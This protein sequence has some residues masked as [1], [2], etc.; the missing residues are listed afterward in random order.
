MSCLTRL[1]EDVWVGY[2]HSSGEVV[3]SVFRFKLPRNKLGL[4]SLKLMS[5][6]NIK[7]MHQT[8]FIFSDRRGAE[9]KYGI[10]SVDLRKE[11]DIRIS[12]GTLFWLVHA[13]W[14]AAEREHSDYLKSPSH[15]SAL[16]HP[17]MWR[18]NLSTQKCSN[19]NIIF[20]VMTRAWPCPCC[21]H[22]TADAP[23]GIDSTKDWQH[24]GGERDWP[25]SKTIHHV[26]HKAL[27]HVKIHT[28]K[29]LGSK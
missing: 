13:Q 16:G 9:S 7:L 21:N 18:C 15:Q 25:G 11:T 20:Y 27:E 22:Q 24:W 17:K 12:P 28:L 8:A 2:C 10:G 4:L 19:C 5:H 26:K 29:G 3:P 23:H 14:D 6:S 1:S